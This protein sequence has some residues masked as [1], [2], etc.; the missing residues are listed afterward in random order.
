MIDYLRAYPV[1]CDLD[2][3]RE[4]VRLLAVDLLCHCKTEL[5]FELRLTETYRSQER[6]NALYASG[7][8]KPGAIITKTERSSHTQGRAFDVCVKGQNP[9]D[10][11]LLTKAGEYWMRNGFTWG[12]VFD[13]RDFCHFE[14]RDK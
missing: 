14:V 11:S 4:D 13:F 1:I 9:F 5:G 2:R 10:I 12:G 3:L 6:Q 7:R 8:T